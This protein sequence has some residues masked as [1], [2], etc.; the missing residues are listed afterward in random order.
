MENADIKQEYVK[1]KLF[2]VNGQESTGVTIEE[3]IY[4]DE[5]ISGLQ[6]GSIKVEVH[7]SIKDTDYGKY[8]ENAIAVQSNAGGELGDIYDAFASGGYGTIA[9]S[10]EIIESVEAVGD[11]EYG[12]KGGVIAREV[13]DV[14]D[15]YTNMQR[16]YRY[17]GFMQSMRAGEFSDAAFQLGRGIA[18]STVQI[19]ISAIGTKLKVPKKYMY[20]FIAGSAAGQKS[21]SL[22]EQRREGN[23]DISNF[24]LATNALLSGAAEAVCCC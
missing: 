4:D 17:P 5:F 7:P 10:L 12:D 22:K 8:L 6:D 14:Q 20:G 15:Q 3:G 13:K 11:L 19:A 1:S 24:Y 9:G 16:M 23:L 21:L 18:G 2:T